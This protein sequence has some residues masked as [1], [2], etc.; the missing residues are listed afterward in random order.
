MAATPSNFD[1]DDEPFGIT[2]IPEGYLSLTFDESKL[3]QSFFGSNSANGVVVAQQPQTQAFATYEASKNE[4]LDPLITL[5]GSLIDVNPHF[6]VYALKNGLIRVLHRHSAMRAL[7]RGHSN[8]VVTD[9]TFFHDGDTLATVG[10]DNKGSGQ[11]STLIVW[12]VY[13]NPPE[14]GSERLLEITNLDFGGAPD[15]TMSRLIWHPFNPNQFWMTHSTGISKQV[16][17]LVETTRIQTKLVLHQDPKDKNPQPQQHAAC[18]W[19]SPYCVMENALQLRESS[20]IDGDGDGQLVDMCWS[21][22]DARHVLS[23]HKNGSIIL[24]DLKSKEKMTGSSNGG[25]G[26]LNAPD[27]DSENDDA[28]GTI[29]PKK[30]YVLKEKGVQHS[31]CLFL[32][33]EQ[34]VTL[35]ANN[36]LESVTTCFV[37]ASTTNSKVT[38]WSAFAQT[39]STDPYGPR[40]PM[41]PTKLQEICFGQTNPSSFVLDI[42]YGPANLN[43][44]QKPP[45]SF[46]LLGSRDT[47]KLYALHVKAEWSQSDDD[48]NNK[49]GA[50]RAP[51]CSGIN[52]MVPFSLKH[53]VYSWSVI[54]GPTQDISEDDA[55]DDFSSSG[56]GFD[57]KAFAY[58]SKAV[59]CLTVTSNMS[60]PPKSSTNSS[61][62]SSSVY[63]VEALEGPYVQAASGTTANAN[64]PEPVYEED[65]Y[66][67][68]DDEVADG[69]ASAA[70]APSVPSASATPTTGGMGGLFPGAANPFANWLGAIAGNNAVDDANDDTDDD[71]DD[72]PTPPAPSDLPM[73]PGIT[74]T[75]SPPPGIMAPPPG[76]VPPTPTT[77]ATANNNNE[78]EAFLNPLE[79]LARSMSGKNPAASAVDTT[80][81]KNNN[82]SRKKNNNRSRS[83]KQP[84]SNA[85]KGSKSNNPFPDG[86]VTILKRAPTPSL[87]LPS[88]PSVLSDP[89]LLAAAGIPIPPTAPIVTQQPVAPF[90]DPSVLEEQIQKAVEAAM[91][92]LVVPAVHKSIQESFATLARPLYKSMDAL[93][94]KGVSVD[95]EDL[96]EALDLETPLKAAFADSMRNVVVPSLQSITGQVLQQV[97]RSMPDPPPP[98]K[99]DSKLLAALVQQL[100]A[101]TSKMDVLSAEVQG[102]RKTVS[103]QAAAAAAQAQAAATA[104]AQQRRSAA[105]SAGNNPAQNNNNNNNSVN[106]ELQIRNQID[107][108]LSKG[109]YEE[110][111]TKAVATTTPQMAVYCCARSD[112]R[113]VLSDGVLSQP[114]LICLMQ[115]LSAALANTQTAQELQIE[116]AWLQ[117]ITLTLNP[118]D[119]SIV[120][121]VPKV[122]R[123]LVANVNGRLALEGTGPFRRPLQMLL[124]SLMGMQLQLG[125]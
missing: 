123:Q 122:L 1:D 36:N 37:T 22:R 46:L 106:T 30:L 11:K 27:D 116:L 45:S 61:S 70:A 21:G 14:I 113:K 97:H 51:L 85:K 108:L 66:D 80:K 120:E 50:N 102:L 64:E 2:A 112:L 31:R 74:K 83:P 82:N 7:L 96:K 73:P 47:G 93:G 107:V 125:N 58:Q 48:N 105:A 75:T 99:D 8:Q 39:K 76:I 59:Q 13:E 49:E 88:D 38:I 56:S 86:K 104:A 117:E 94:K 124:N 16:A 89:A 32:P 84:Q 55:D 63:T 67:V 43:G 57:I 44:K 87:P 114:I 23:V 53:P 119:P 28:S 69:V 109:K 15:L 65:E 72:L 9:I 68:D 95:S 100:Q 101:M 35:H 19:H 3:E 5:N 26:G 71:D 90:I 79:L 78:E 12:R 52:Y 54:C 62:Q 91:S 18:Q 103:E 111:F 92:N 24:W 118:I 41:N 40:S 25:I 98:P 115:Q 4:S 77:N 60:L 6:V 81:D 33:H 20:S 42:C 110:A 121:H 10:N 29:L 17:T 34:S